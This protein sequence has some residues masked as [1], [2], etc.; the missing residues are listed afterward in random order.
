MNIV[1]EG[2]DGSGKST[3]ASY[4]SAELGM[5][6]VQGRGPVKPGTEQS[7]FNEHRGINGVIFDRHVCVSEMIYG[8]LFQRQTYAAHFYQQ[9]YDANHII[10]YCRAPSASLIDHV[11]SSPTDTPEYLDQLNT[12]FA[13]VVQRYDEWAMRHAH[14]IYRRDGRNPA[15]A[16]LINDLTGH[17]HEYMTWRIAS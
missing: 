12:Y 2:P 10:V 14:L 9:I 15:M 1:L 11:A 8:P 17:L 3:L 4:L 13:Q 6:I 7:R 5:P 16:A